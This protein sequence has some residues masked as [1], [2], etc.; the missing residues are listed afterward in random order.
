MERPNLGTS[1]VL[2]PSLFPPMSLRSAQPVPL[3][4]VPAVT[5]PRHLAPTVGP[6][7]SGVDDQAGSLIGS[8]IAVGRFIQFGSLNFIDEATWTPATRNVTSGT[9]L[10][11][12]SIDIFIGF[13][14]SS[15]EGSPTT[16]RIQCM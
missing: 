3:A 8:T 4:M 5:I 1:C 7:V 15:T 10:P 16:S 11:V 14:G 2:I 9:V 13:V 12:G 6:R